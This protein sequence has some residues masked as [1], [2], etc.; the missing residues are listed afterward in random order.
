LSRR[1]GA[2]L[3]WDWRVFLLVAVMFTQQ[4]LFGGQGAVLGLLFS[5]EDAALLLALLSAPRYR[6]Y[7]S[8]M[9]DV[10]ILG[11]LLLFI[12]IVQ[13][14]DLTPLFPNPTSIVW[15][16][17]DAPPRAAPDPASVIVECTKLLAL[18][19]LFLCGALLSRDRRQREALLSYLLIGGIVFALFCLVLNALNLTPMTETKA[20]ISTGRVSG[21][22]SSPNTAATAF[23]INGVLAAG[24]FFRKVSSDARAPISK[25]RLFSDNP[26]ELSGLLLNTG[27]LVLTGSRGG[28]LAYAI[29]LSILA[30]PALIRGGKTK[31]APAVAGLFLVGLL[32]ASTGAGMLI[33]RFFHAENVTSGRWEWLQLYF[34]DALRAPTG[35][36]GLGSFASVN[37][38]YVTPGNFKLTSWA[39][40][41]HDLYVQWLLEGGLL[42]G[43]LVI[44]I[45]LSALTTISLNKGNLR[46]LILSIIVLVSVNSI[47]EYSMQ[48][49]STSSLLFL[50]IGIGFGSIRPLTRG[51][52]DKNHPERLM[53][54]P[55]PV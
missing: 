10:A 12:L 50:M 7:L 21:L 27:C 3:I 29:A 9:K 32:V 6:A 53:A 33:D 55:N 11:A 34:Q 4:M 14:L 49:F 20:S 41:V 43:T 26:L 45:V 16:L 40:T 5:L 51:P 17:V 54:M 35:G 48:E 38:F 18:A 13:I 1:E 24:L 25:Y 44:L 22:F 19:C 23:A 2:A 8:E 39:G 47:Y 36:Y 31:Q 30:G 46:I 42:C 15:R 52:R 28:L 37:R